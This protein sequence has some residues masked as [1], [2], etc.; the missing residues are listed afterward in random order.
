M[1]TQCVALFV[2]TKT[3]GLKSKNN[4]FNV[5]TNIYSI[6]FYT[7]SLLKNTY[8]VGIAVIKADIM[9]LSDVLQLHK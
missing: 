2:L 4:E 1:I 9:P 3:R 5:H 6:I 8:F 7:G